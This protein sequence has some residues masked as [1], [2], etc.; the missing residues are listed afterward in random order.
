MEKRRV[1]VS[2]WV[3]GACGALL[4]IGCVMLFA[5]GAS[6]DRAIDYPTNEAGLSYG[7]A[8]AAVSL[9]TEPDL[10]KV[11]A[12][13]DREGYVHKDQF[14]AAL[15]PA[16]C[17]EEALAMMKDRHDRQAAAFAGYLNRANPSA[18][19]RATQVEA[20]GL[21]DEIEE[22]VSCQGPNDDFETLDEI[23]ARVAGE[24][25]VDQGV[26]QGAY[27]AAVAATSTAIPVYDVDGTTQ[28]GE[29]VIQ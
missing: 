8:D 15:K 14:H 28:I 3:V 2:A 26:V 24:S 21:Y 4:A 22:S 20:V 5:Q 6:A 29:F 25:G 16:S 18:T 11:I 13:N 9:D 1:R 17:P 7:S 10:I 27:D 19:S 23:V 12:T